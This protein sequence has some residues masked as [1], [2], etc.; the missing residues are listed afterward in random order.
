LITTE[1]NNFKDIKKV[2]KIKIV[3][4]TQAPNPKKRPNKLPEIKPIRGKNTIKLYINFYFIIL[5]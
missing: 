5:P 3:V 1:K 2:Q 4:I